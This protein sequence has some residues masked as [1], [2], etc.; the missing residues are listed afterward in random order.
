MK[1]HEIS[2]HEISQTD[3]QT[4]I[5]DSSKKILLFTPQPL[6]NTIHK[7]NF[8]PRASSSSYPVIVVAFDAHQ[9]TDHRRRSRTVAPSC[10]PGAA[11]TA[12]PATHRVLC[13]PPTLVPV[14]L[15]RVAG[16]ISLRRRTTIRTRGSCRAVTCPLWRACGEANGQRRR[17]RPSLGGERFEG[18]KTPGSGVE[19]GGSKV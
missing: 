3:Y 12:T 16:R 13:D 17:R 14:T 18:M 5:A 8:K 11:R 4:C 7:H 10:P 6:F 15:A 19:G 9:Q 2:M 1:F